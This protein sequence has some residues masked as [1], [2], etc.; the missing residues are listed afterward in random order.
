MK[1]T[2]TLYKHVV[3]AVRGIRAV[4]NAQIEIEICFIKQE[5]IT[6]QH[7]HNHVVVIGL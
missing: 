7:W 1:I 5:N 2:Q 4:R 3:A 6:I